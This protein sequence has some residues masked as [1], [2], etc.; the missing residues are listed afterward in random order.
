M[1][2]DSRKALVLGIIAMSLVAV[3]FVAKN[4]STPPTTDL[5]VVS[6]EGEMQ[7]IDLTAKGGFSPSRVEA[8]AGVP[9]TLR[10]TTNGTYDCSST[11]VIPA[12]NYQANLEPTGVE[13]INLTSEQ[14]QGTLKGMCSMGMYRF[15]IAFN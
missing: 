12:L 7:F 8:Q 6:M 1:Q 5:S 4:S 9:T 14:A 3:F 11:L 10:V 15:E 13:L 2:T